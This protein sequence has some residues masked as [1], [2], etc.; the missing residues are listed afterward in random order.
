MINS[1]SELKI[2]SLNATSIGSQSKRDRVF[3]FLKKR[4]TDIFVVVDTRIDPKR[5]QKVK[6]DWGGQAYF[7]SFSSQSR[8]IA[9]FLKKNLPIKITDSKKDNEGNLLQL[10]IEFNDKK[11]LLSGLYGPNLDSP[12]FYKE[13]VFSAIDV[14]LPDYSIFVGDW[15]LV[16]DQ[17]KDTHNY[18]RNNNVMARNTVIE[19]IE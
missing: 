14:F 5:E 2:E 1:I 18:L 4:D 16:M 11:I 6:E 17:Q 10:L 13:I 8:G 19:K 15:N 3:N 7:S 9:I 12:D